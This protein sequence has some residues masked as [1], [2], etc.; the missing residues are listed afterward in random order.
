MPLGYGEY[1]ATHLT[2]ISGGHTPFDAAAAVA[3]AAM[4]ADQAKA[5]P[6]TVRS[7]MRWMRFKAASDVRRTPL[8]LPR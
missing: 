7:T 6:T 1:G 2:P 3:A 8:R 5:M 4:P